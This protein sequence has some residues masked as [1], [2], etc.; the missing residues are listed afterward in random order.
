M[1]FQPRSWFPVSKLKLHA[2]SPVA[3]C[4]AFELG[5]LLRLTICHCTFASGTTENVLDETAEYVWSIRARA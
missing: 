3:S 2:S 4:H 5:A 1:A